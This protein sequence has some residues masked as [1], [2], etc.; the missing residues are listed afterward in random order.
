MQSLQFNANIAFQPFGALALNA[1]STTDVSK[2][3]G[4]TL[5]AD[6]IKSLGIEPV[7]VTKNGTLWNEGS[8]NE[9][10]MKIIEKLKTDMETKE[11]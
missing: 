6:F 4:F 11:F 2:I 8:V 9:I 7:F 1:I 5:R 3:I 10:R